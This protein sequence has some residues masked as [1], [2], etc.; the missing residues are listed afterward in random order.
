L[1]ISI[2]SGE[3]S[4]WLKLA[5]LPE[6]APFLRKNPMAAISDT[7]SAG[8]KN[9]FQHTFN[10]E[11]W[12]WRGLPLALHLGRLLSIA[13]GAATVWLAW[14][15]SRTVFDGNL[16]LTMAATGLVAFNP[17]FIFISASFNND[18]LVT[19]LVTLALWMA[20]K[21]DRT[22][23]LN[24]RH[25]LAAGLLAGLAILTKPT[26]WIAGLGLAAVF[27]K[28]IV[29]PLTANRRPPTTARHLPPRNQKP[30]TRNQ[31]LFTI[32]YS[33]FIMLLT[34]LTVAGW[35]I[36]R[37]QLLYH[38]PLL[39]NYMLAYL[40][41]ASPQL[42]TPLQLWQRFL[43]AEISFWA[44]FGWLN[45]TIPEAFYTIYRLILRFSWL[46][47]GVGMALWLLGR[48]KDWQ[49]IAHRMWLP[50]L[51]LAATAATMW[52]WVALAGG[53]Q[54]RLLFPAIVPLALLTVWGASHWSFVLC[55]SSFVIR[56]SSL[57]ARHASRSFA[58]LLLSYFLGV[59][60]YSLFFVL[61]PAYAPPPILDSLP[62]SVYSTNI[63][64]EE[65]ITLSGYALPDA[66]LQ[67]GQ[68]A[69]LTLYWRANAPIDRP[70]AVFVHAVDAETGAIIAQSQS[71]AG[72][73]L[74]PADQWPATGYVQDHLTLSI[75]GLT[76]APATGNF[77][78]GL[79]LPETG[80]R[81]LLQ[82]GGTSAALREYFD[83]VQYKFRLLP[84][85]GPFDVNWQVNFERGISL[86]GYDLPRRIL[87]PGD[88]LALTLHWQT[89]RPL[90]NNYTV[91]VHL[92]NRQGERIAQRDSW[93]ANGQAP[94]AA[95]L[96]DQPISD[97]HQITL[98]P[99]LPPGGYRLAVGLYNGETGER[100]P[101][102]TGE[103]LFGGDMLTL[104][105]IAV[106]PY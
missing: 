53:I 38:D 15:I 50:L 25:G 3:N 82:N 73:G 57:V 92:L 58:F 35:W 2:I 29:Q 61:R 83:G 14:W 23:D 20:I 87:S 10:V 63:Q 70:Y 78:V 54:G 55:P 97:S 46:G 42:P 65:G 104:T 76:Y 79:F 30:K 85:P 43:E 60:L 8:N 21:F 32:H 18:N 59:S 93:P 74:F 98:P 13:M 9:A 45:I 89:N 36:W 67:P 40:N 80:E 44:T 5:G 86:R 99:N 34:A 105:E 71:F 49:T 6:T 31:K 64:F 16:W 19:L 52:Q 77:V 26:G 39:R 37:N 41:V 27:V 88:A 96:P 95:W 81:L 103:V 72:R 7:A 22:L 101:L 28:R 106:S 4:V 69:K 56:H 1:Q 48:N 90:Q 47:L 11:N 24:W 68:L 62:A 102:Q 51:W 17:Q 94:T 12:P 75:P 66:P 84:N 91:F 100:I 33:L